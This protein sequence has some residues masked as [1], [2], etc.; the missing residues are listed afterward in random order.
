MDNMFHN[1]ILLFFAFCSF[2]QASNT[3]ASLRRKNTQLDALDFIL[4]KN[5]HLDVKPILSEQISRPGQ[6]ALMCAKNA[7]CFSFNFAKVSDGSGIQSCDLLDSD[8]YKETGKF[9]PI[10]GPS[11]YSIR[12]SKAPIYK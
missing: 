8:M 10:N 1:S 7:S 5:A 12:V 2:F 11:H 9:K 6:C 3:I 4:F